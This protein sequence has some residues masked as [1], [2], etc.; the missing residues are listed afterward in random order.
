MAQAKENLAQTLEQQRARH[1]WKCVQEIDKREDRDKKRYRT[2][3][4]KAPVLVLTNGLGQ[5]AAFLHDGNEKNTVEERLYQHL[6]SW[7]LERV[8]G[9]QAQ[10]DLLETITQRWTSAQYRRATEEALAF[11]TWLKRFAEA[12]L[13][14]PEGGETP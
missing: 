1:A 3:A 7:L 13:P 12:V 11:L 2:L 9:A 6:S 14:E 5:T 4:L 8:G 10:D